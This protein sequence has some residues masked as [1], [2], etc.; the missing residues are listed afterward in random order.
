MMDTGRVNSQTV[1]SLNKGVEPRKL[2]SWEY[3]WELS[4]GLV[5]PHMKRRK[6]KGGLNKALLSTI[7]SL[8]VSLGDGADEPQ[9]GG[10]QVLHPLQ[11]S[12]RRCGP[13]VA[14]LKTKR[15]KAEKDTL[16]K[17]K[18]QCQLCCTALCK[19]HAVQ[20]CTSCSVRGL[21]GE[22]DEPVA[23]PEDDNLFSSL[24]Y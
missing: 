21:P 13:C 10:G 9:Q 20:I 1:H 23:E 19:A 18:T 8:I 7:G 11:G 2:D 16:S 12:R 5:M 6:A 17:Q 14:D 15:H 4:L 22:Q 24:M 3:G